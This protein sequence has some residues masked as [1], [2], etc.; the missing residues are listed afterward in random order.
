VSPSNA[1]WDEWLPCIS[2]LQVQNQPQQDL[3]L[4]ALLTPFDTSRYEA[5][6]ADR[7]TRE[8]LL[9]APPNLYCDGM[10]IRPPLRSH[11]TQTREGLPHSSQV[12]IIHMRDLKVPHLERAKPVG[13]ICSRAPQ[14]GSAQ[15]YATFV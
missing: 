8:V 3:L 5:N 9:L 2:L 4:G 13:Y 14:V 10:F 12:M 15:Y 1:P 7:A 11:D 6:E